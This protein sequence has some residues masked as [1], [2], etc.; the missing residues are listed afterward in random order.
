MK[1]C[2]A[3]DKTRRIDDFGKNKTRVDGLQG[4]CNK[5]R[6]KY[7]KI[8]ADKLNTLAKDYYIKNSLGRLEYGKKYYIENKED[9][10][11]YQNKYGKVNSERISNYSKGYRKENEDKIRKDKKKYFEKNRIIIYAKRKQRLQVDLNFKLA[12]NLRSR[13]SMAVSSKA[14]LK[15]GSAVQDLGCSIEEFKIYIQKLF[16]EN[17]AWENY[18]EWHLDHIFPLASFDLTDREQFLVACNYVNYQPLWAIDNLKKGA[19]I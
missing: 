7:R 2:P 14:G 4:N 12:A 5:C 16:Q 11:K 3:C 10:L 19:R 6:A 1:Y 17:M 8:N 13:I 18:G 9:K 15:S